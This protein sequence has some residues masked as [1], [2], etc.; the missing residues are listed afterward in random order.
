LSACRI[1]PDETF[2]AD[3]RLDALVFAVLAVSGIELR[4]LR[5]DPEWIE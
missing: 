1:E 2:N 3:Q 4:L 5:P